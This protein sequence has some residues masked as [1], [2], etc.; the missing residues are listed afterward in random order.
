MDLLLLLSRDFENVLGQNVSIRLNTLS[1]TCTDLVASSHVKR[2]DVRSSKT[3]LL[4]P[5]IIYYRPDVLILLI[6]VIA[7]LDFYGSFVR[8]LGKPG[9]GF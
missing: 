1:N 7:H 8:N 3:S 2:V 5:P 6:V 9:Q 4:I